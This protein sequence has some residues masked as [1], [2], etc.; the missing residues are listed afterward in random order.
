MD[1]P[2]MNYL[3]MIQSPLKVFLLIG[4]EPEWDC[5]LPAQTLRALHQADVVI[6]I[7][8]FI[9][10]AMREYCDW[11]LP[12]KCYAEAQG[13]KINLE[14]KW[15]SY[16]KVIEADAEIKDGWKILR[17][18]GSQLK[19]EGFDYISIEDV[20]Q[21]ISQHLDKTLE[22]SNELTSLPKIEI[23][24]WD[25]DTVFSTGA[26]PLYSIDSLV[27][28][29]NSLKQAQDLDESVIMINRIDVEKHGL[30]DGKWVKVSQGQDSSIF[31]CVINNNVQVGTVY[32]PRGLPRS[33][34]L[35]GVFDAVQLKNL[36]VA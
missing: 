2:G 3:Q 14:G 16:D 9:T 29:A 18:L 26:V 33:E 13:T 7:N 35:G 10:E 20:R 8:S 6:S 12:M 1:E 11:V 15:Q 31:K 28:N 4:L 25:V 23:K 34:K 21:E 5:A 19:L 17:M 30:I 32:I 24:H 27:R 36:S 22:F